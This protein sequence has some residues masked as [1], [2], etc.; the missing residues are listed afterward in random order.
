MS[1]FQRITIFGR[2]GKDPDKRFTQN[3]KTV[4]EIRVA[5]DGKDKDGNKV[6]TWY[7]V[8]FFE[9]Q[10]DSI[11]QYVKKGSGIIV[12]GDLELELWTDRDGNAQVTPV[13]KFAKFIL[14]DRAGDR[15][16]QPNGAQQAVARA[17]ERA[18]SSDALD[19]IFAS[20][21]EIPF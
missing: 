4:A 9:K 5:V 10:A 18:K 12:E 19:A 2:V 6:T 15:A 17:H 13:I 7:K 21:D 14:T 1:G 11:L 3:Q 16:Q 20:E 8:A